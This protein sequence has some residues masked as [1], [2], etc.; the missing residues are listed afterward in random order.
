MNLGDGW[1][2]II[3]EA[4]SWARRLY[5]EEGKTL[6]VNAVELKQPPGLLDLCAGMLM[7]Q[8]A[9]RATEE[10]LYGRRGV[11][12]TTAKGVCPL[13]PPQKRS[14]PLLSST[15]CQPDARGTPSSLSPCVTLVSVSK[16]PALM[17]A[18]MY[19]GC[20]PSC[21]LAACPLQCEMLRGS[22]GLHLA[23]EDMA[24][25]HCSIVVQ[26]VL[27]LEHSWPMI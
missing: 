7:P 27:D 16:V 1:L 17:A 5:P 24:T 21:V 20:W 13:P 12:I 14:L 3:Q 18:A 19:T 26:V 15:C 25:S 11:T 23:K 6:K 2:C 10:A 9:A 4:L 8:Y 22:T